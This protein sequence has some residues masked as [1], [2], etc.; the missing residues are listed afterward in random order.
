MSLIGWQT[1][2]Q[3]HWEKGHRPSKADIIEW[4]SLGILSGRVI[5]TPSKTR[6]DVDETRFLS[7]GPFHAPVQN[8]STPDLLN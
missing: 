2:T 3:R 4:I 5:E 1:F 7:T 6:V 8:N